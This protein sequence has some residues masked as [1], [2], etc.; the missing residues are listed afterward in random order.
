[1]LRSPNKNTTLTDR[2]I[3]Q[4][5]KMIQISNEEQ[6]RRSLFLSGR[7]NRYTEGNTNNHNRFSLPGETIIGMIDVGAW[8]DNNQ[9]ILVWNIFVTPTKGILWPWNLWTLWKK[10]NDL[11]FYI[12]ALWLGLHPEPLLVDLSRPLN[13]GMVVED[14]E[15]TDG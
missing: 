15:S 6:A 3:L 10:G 4:Y 2:N 11:L 5:S 7:P 1:M 14:H 12:A 9:G 13:S 8:K